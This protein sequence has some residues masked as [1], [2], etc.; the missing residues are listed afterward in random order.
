MLRCSHVTLK[1]G[2]RWH[3]GKEY[4]Q[5]SRGMLLFVE[6]E[7][8]TQLCPTLCNPMD[9]SLPGSSIHEILQTR[10][11][12]WVAISFSRGSSQPRDWT[13]V[14]GIAGR[15][16]TVW[17]TRKALISYTPIQNKKL[18]KQNKVG[19]QLQLLPIL[20]SKLNPPHSIFHFLKLTW[21]S[22]S[23]SR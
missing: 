10:I 17:A 3:K 7:R 2:V 8:V 13:G 6:S 22:A 19:L 20:S 9:C 5:C 16:F 1:F 12:E 21:S 15:F 11:L 14:S 4:Q 23:T 18:N